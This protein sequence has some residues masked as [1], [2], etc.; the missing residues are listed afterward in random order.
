MSHIRALDPIP[1]IPLPGCRVT[2][3]TFPVLSILS[4]SVRFPSI[5]TFRC[6]RPWCRI[7]SL[8]SACTWP[9]RALLSSVSSLTTKGTGLY[10]VLV[11]LKFTHNI[12]LRREAGTASSV[13]IYELQTISPLIY[14]FL[15]DSAF[16]FFLCVPRLSILWRQFVLNEVCLYA[17]C[18]SVRYVHALRYLLIPTAH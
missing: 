4:W 1:Q 16:Y 7:I 3:P 15:R 9:R 10:F 8:L 11:L 13:P 18:Q 12:S 17:T 5:H 14:S 2:A 6:S